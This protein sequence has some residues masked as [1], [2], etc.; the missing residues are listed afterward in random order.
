MTIEK[1]DWQKQGDILEIPN[2]WIVDHAD[3]DVETPYIHISPVENSPDFKNYS[4]GRM[5][6][7]PKSLAYFLSV[8]FCGSYLMS[9]TLINSGRND[10][11]N[12]I[13]EALGIE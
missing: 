1:H 9:D 10:V 3:F 7:V 4:Q 11:R 8:H 12:K 2:D 5:L 13:K 6:R